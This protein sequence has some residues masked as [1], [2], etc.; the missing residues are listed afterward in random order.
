MVSLQ[1]VGHIMPMGKV[2]LLFLLG[3]SVALAVGVAFMKL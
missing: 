1:M 3:S 2:L